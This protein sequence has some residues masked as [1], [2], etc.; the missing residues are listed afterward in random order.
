VYEKKAATTEQKQS[1]VVVGNNGD[2][3]RLCYA[4][5]VPLATLATIHTMYIMTHR[6]SVFLM[7]SYLYESEE[8]HHQ[9][10]IQLSN[11]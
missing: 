11:H 5:F 6:C 1:N 7:Q 2:V 3:S 4:A 8:F 10:S 9:Y